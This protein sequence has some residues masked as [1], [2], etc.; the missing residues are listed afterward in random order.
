MT[1]LVEPTDADVLE[2]AAEIVAR[3][4]F[5]QYNPDGFISVFDGLVRS[6]EW[7]VDLIESLRALQ[8]TSPG[9]YL[10][11]MLGLLVVS[12]G[13]IAHIV[14]AVSSAMKTPPAPE[15]EAGSEAKRVD[16]AAEA[17]ALAANGRYLEAAHRLLLASLARMAQARVIEL[18]PDHTNEIV[19]SRIRAS[20]LPLEL[21]DELVGLI[22]R[23]ERA[24]FG[25]R[26]SE[27]ALYEDWASTFEKLVVATPA[28]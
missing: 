19:S 18:E 7:F 16:F 2:H 14:W 8:Q 4:E 26:R 17:R 28:G 1:L 24:W 15:L 25:T 13:L 20:S 12:L 3:R 6:L 9:L 21:R 22:G 11:I 27:P 10:L 5:A 23:T